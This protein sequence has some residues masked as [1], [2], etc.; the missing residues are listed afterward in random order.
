VRFQDFLASCTDEELTTLERHVHPAETPF[1][2]GMVFSERR[3][4][5]TRP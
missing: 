1:I 4:R 3:M 5:E 2:A